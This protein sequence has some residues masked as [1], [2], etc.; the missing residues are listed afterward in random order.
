M[1]K[2]A[3]TEKE[4]ERRL[5]VVKSR[6][7]AHSAGVRQLSIGSVGVQVYDREMAI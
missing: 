2:N 6:G 4:L 5:Y 7:M 3:R 1:L